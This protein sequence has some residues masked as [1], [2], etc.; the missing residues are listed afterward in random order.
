MHFPGA[1]RRV[2]PHFSSLLRR[3]ISS[4]P[5]TSFDLKVIGSRPPPKEFSDPIHCMSLL[6]SNQS[7]VIQGAAATPT[8]LIDAM[9]KYAKQEKLKNTSENNNLDIP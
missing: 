8:F 5:S 2:L 4:S 7:V 6:E 9:C 1:R 3:K